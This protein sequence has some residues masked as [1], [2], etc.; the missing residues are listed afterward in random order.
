[1]D[2]QARGVQ[3]EA[4]AERFLARHGVSTLARRLRC[5]GGEIDLICLEGAT[6]L[7]VEVRL[8]APGRFGNA[9]DSITPLKQQRIIHAAHWWLSRDGRKHAQRAMRFDAVLFDQLDTRNAHWLRGAFE[10]SAW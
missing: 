6:L 8:R 1:M 3:A 4:L 9:A 5:R 10:A 2:A 7:F